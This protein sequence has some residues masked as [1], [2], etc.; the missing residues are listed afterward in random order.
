MGKLI[1]I[2]GDAD[3]VVS[4]ARALS[5][6]AAL[7]ALAA[8]PVVSAPAASPA[9]AVEPTPAAESA[10]AAAEREAEVA[11]IGADVLGQL[12]RDWCHNFEVE[13]AP[14]PPRDERLMAAF[15]GYG[16]AIRSFA[17]EKG[18]LCN[19]IIDCLLRSS[20]A[21]PDEAVRLGKRI[22]LNMMQ[23]GSALGMPIDGLIERSMFHSKEDQLS[24]KPPFGG[25]V[26]DVVSE[27]ATSPRIHPPDYRSR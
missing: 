14:Q 2:I 26:A 8:L 23:V 9:P 24:D 16:K 5:G 10:S 3:D 4:A 6:A 1:L 7:P 20:I 21:Q 22:G 17:R 27:E 11:G 13:G 25:M 18:G 15:A 19:A 12:V